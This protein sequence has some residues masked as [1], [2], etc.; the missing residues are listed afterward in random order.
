MARFIGYC[1]A[2][3]MGTYLAAD[4]ETAANNA[5]AAAD[6][7]VA[8]AE[9]AAVEEVAA[10]E[11]LHVEPVVATTETVVAPGERLVQQPNGQVVV[12]R[13]QGAMGG[14]L[15]WVLG[16]GVILALLMANK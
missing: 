15:P 3:G 2:G 1:C 9:A 6:A 8:E 7:A 14:M 13:E 16:G 11:A 10:Q 4:E 12:I 5:A